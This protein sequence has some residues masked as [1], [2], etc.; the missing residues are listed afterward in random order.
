M[1]FRIS[2][3]G[4][5]LKGPLKRRHLEAPFREEGL[6]PGKFASLNLLER[7]SLGLV[8]HLPFK[9]LFLKNP[10]RFY[11]VLDKRG[12]FLNPFGLVGPPHLEL[13]N[14]KTRPISFLFPPSVYNHRLGG[15][16]GK[17]KEGPNFGRRNLPGKP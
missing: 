2:F 13:V 10:F 12:I 6:H 7:E 9:A 3:F 15:P 5:L 8:G 14:S 11:E 17:K 4:G 16:S 1:G